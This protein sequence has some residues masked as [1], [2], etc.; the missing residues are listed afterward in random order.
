MTDRLAA[1]TTRSPQSQSPSRDSLSAR[2]MGVVSARLT[3]LDLGL[4]LDLS[5]ILDL[6]LSLG[7]IF[8]IAFALPAP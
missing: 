2:L 3:P 4:S 7:L 5:L 1:L 6:D 8:H